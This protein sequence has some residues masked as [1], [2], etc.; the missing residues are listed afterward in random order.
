MIKTV[1]CDLLGI[2]YPI[3]QG[4]M[5]WVSLAPL[6]AAVSEAGGF[7]IIGA[8]NAPPEWVREQIAETRRRTA[9]PFG[10]NLALMSPYVEGVVQVC[11]EER[12]AA[13]TAGGGNPGPYMEP[14]KRAGIKVIP[15]VASIALGR[16]LERMGADLL[17]AEG[18]ESGGHIGE[19]ATM[20]LV[21]QMVDAVNIPV[22]AAGGIADG[23]GLA[24]A[25]ALGAV[26]IQM[27]TRFVCT[28]ECPV[29]IN[30]KQSIIK[31][32]DR[33]TI[34]TGH[35]INHPVR[36]LKNPFVLEFHELETRG[37]S[38]EEVVAFGMGALRRASMEGDVVRGSV[39]A[40]QIAG[41]IKDIRPVRELIADIIAEAEEVIMRRLPSVVQ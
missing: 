37:A 4:G 41:M 20:P 10:V 31:A 27:G 39:M 34:T 30:Y 21:P 22:V 14:L 28:E 18:M 12:V 8:G 40:G 3:I 9:R 35:T 16:R 29:H 25:L 26:G 7:G 38:D 2:R 32:H 19:T 5:S 1:L 24:A 17:V 11:I 6:A 36:C 33:A 15:V 23:R 13:V